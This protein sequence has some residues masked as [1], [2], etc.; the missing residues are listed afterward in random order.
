[1]HYR[2]LVISISENEKDILR[3]ADYNEA[4]IQNLNDEIKETLNLKETLKFNE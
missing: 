2:M 1:M 4:D 3:F